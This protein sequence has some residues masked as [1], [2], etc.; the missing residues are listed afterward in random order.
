MGID[1]KTYDGMDKMDTKSRDLLRSAFGSR[2]LFYH[3]VFE[4]MRDEIGN[5]LATKIMRKAIYRRGSDISGNFS[6]Y[7]P[8]DLKGLKEAFLN[9]IPDAEEMFAPEVAENTDDSLRIHFHRCPLKEAWQDSGIEGE[10][11]E[12]MCDMAGCVDKGTFGE[13][14]FNIEVD[15]WKQGREGCCRLHI[16]PGPE[17]L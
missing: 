15:T 5:E 11:L 3:A 4:E 14:G 1:L 17:A 12:H 8:S 10:E 7:A 9:F 6:P 13:A 2:A 16:T